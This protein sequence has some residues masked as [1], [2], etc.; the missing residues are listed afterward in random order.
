MEY[1]QRRNREKAHTLRGAK[2]QNL[3]WVWEMELTTTANNF[4]RCA[5]FCHLGG[6][7]RTRLIK[8]PYC[9]TRYLA[10]SLML[11]SAVLRHGINLV[12]RPL[13]T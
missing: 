3:E 13:P 6:R 8:T 7:V 2:V 5:I 11:A 4:N 1:H 12:P 9:T 10:A